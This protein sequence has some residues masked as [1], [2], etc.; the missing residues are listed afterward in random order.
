M[1]FLENFFFYH[2]VIMSTD[3]R[4]CIMFDMV[5][6]EKEQYTYI[7]FCVQKVLTLSFTLSNLYTSHTVYFLLFCAVCKRSTQFDRETEQI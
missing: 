3:L 4:F 1:R 6:R 2:S 7:W 5:A